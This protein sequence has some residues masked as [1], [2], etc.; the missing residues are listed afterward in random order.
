MVN[1]KVPMGSRLYVSVVNAEDESQSCFL[2][3][4]SLRTLKATQV[5]TIKSS[6]FAQRI[7]I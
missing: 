2:I 4:R 7:S 6:S 3:H 5:P 1:F